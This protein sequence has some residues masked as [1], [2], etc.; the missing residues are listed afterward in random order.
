M[1]RYQD[2]ISKTSFFYYRISA[3][4]SAFLPDLTDL[5]DKKSRMIALI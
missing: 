4:Y 5:K 1:K 3:V 2:A